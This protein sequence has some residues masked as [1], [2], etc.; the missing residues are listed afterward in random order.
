M[1]N[2][3]ITI[4]KKIFK[5]LLPIFRLLCSIFFNKKYLTGKYF[6]ESLMGWRWVLRSIVWQKFYGFNRHI[7]W[8]ASPF[9]TISSS[10]NIEFDIN[11]INNFQ[12]YG[13][14]FQN[15]GGRIVIGKGTYIAPNVGLITSNHD[16][17]DLDKHLDSQ[18]IIIG[19]KCWIGINA[20]LLPGVTLG[21]HT[22]VGAGSIVTKSFPDGNVII[23]GNPAKMIR[24]LDEDQ[25]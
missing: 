22:I 1:P 13:T 11:D 14:Y 3:K 25:A 16:P 9:I 21:D 5:F 23:A 12:T 2:Q 20:V 17:K 8:P 18:D 10:D 24:K 7:P 6:D 15:F 4:K 19:R